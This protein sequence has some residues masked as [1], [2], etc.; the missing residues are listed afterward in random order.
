MIFFV[1]RRSIEIS[2]QFSFNASSIFH[3]LTFNEH[4][5]YHS[6][7]IGFEEKRRNENSN[8]RVHTDTWSQGKSEQ[9]QE[10]MSKKE[11]EK[12]GE[13][14]WNWSKMFTIQYVFIDGTFCERERENRQKQ[15]KK[16]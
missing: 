9:D 16:N 6:W 4:R 3:R 11:I 15:H 12:E 10:R 8:R 14:E 7:Q 1:R 2:S 5:K 13:K